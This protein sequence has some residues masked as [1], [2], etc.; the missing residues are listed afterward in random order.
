M[1]IFK[2]FAPKL[3]KIVV[4]LTVISLLLTSAV[5][6][7][8]GGGGKDSGGGVKRKCGVGVNGDGDDIVWPLPVGSH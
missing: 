3:V 2:H 7:G 4:V 6:P 8:G 1:T 5:A